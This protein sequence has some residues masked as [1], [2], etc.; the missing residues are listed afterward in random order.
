MQIVFDGQYLSV[1]ANSR[2]DVDLEVEMMGEGGRVEVQHGL[3]V[4]EKTSLFWERIPDMR[5]GDRFHFRYS[6][7]TDKPMSAIVSHL[8]V[9]RLSG[10]GL[11][12]DLLRARMRIQPGSGSLGSP[13][14]VHQL[15]VE[16]VPS[17]GDPAGATLR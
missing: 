12:L 3:I 9:K 11:S 7:S 8:A 1:P 4:H 13:L 16:L 2:I 15:D 17:L 14:V 6:Y 5:P 10:S